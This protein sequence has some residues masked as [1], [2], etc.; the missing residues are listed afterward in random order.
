M[1]QGERLVG[2]DAALA[3]LR[4]ALQ[5]AARGRGELVLLAGEAGIGKTALAAELAR[6]ADAAGAL[7]LWGQCWQGE[8][9]PAY[10]PWVQ[11]LRAAAEADP[12]AALG[13]A[14]RL[15]SGGDGAPA[16][17]GEEPTAARFRLFDAVVRVLAGLAG[18]QPL[19]LVL[20]D[21]HW[22]DEAS[23]RLLRFAARHLAPSPVLLLGTYRDLEAPARLPQVGLEVLARVLPDRGSDLP[24]LL[25]EAV[26]ARVLTP[27][28]PLGPYRFAHDLFRE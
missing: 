5:G 27:E 21:L 2:R 16:G 24:D 28:Q 8:A 14:G 23:L 1:S 13:D 17:R 19:V 7:V 15:L 3:V 6:Q 11:V 18:R 20:D 22:A 25:G 12:E 4:A 26:R 10:W 9:V